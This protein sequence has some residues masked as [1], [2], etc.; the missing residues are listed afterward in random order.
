MLEM[1]HRR[2]IHWTTSMLFQRRGE[3]AAASIPDTPAWFRPI[4]LLDIEIGQP[5]AAIRPALDH[6]GQP[7][8]RALALLRW[9]DRPVA[10]VAFELPASGLEPDAVRSLLR[11]ELEAPSTAHLL[12]ANG[13]VPPDVT[14]PEPRIAEV[15]ARDAF[16]LRAPLASVVIATRNRPEQLALCLASLAELVYPAFEIIVVD[17]APS[18][19]RTARY[20]A[21][22]IG[23]RSNLRYVREDRAGLASAHNCGVREMSPQSHFVAFTDDDVAVD[24][25]WLAELIRGFEAASNVGCVTG[26]IL[27]A[28]LETWPQLLIE[29]F[30]GFNKGFQRQIFDLRDHRPP[31]RLF[32]FT[33]GRFGSGANMA[34]RTETL[35][36][37]GGF[38]PAMGTGTAALGGD[39][40]AAFFRVITAGEALVYEPAAIVRHTHYRAYA[41]L[42]RQIHGYGVGL[43]AFLTKAIVDQP[44][45]AVDLLRKLPLGLWYALSACSGKNQKKGTDYPE[46]LTRLERKGLVQGPWAYLRSRR[47]ALAHDRARQSDSRPG[48]T[49][50]Q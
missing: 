10:S 11:R 38:D 16:L 26:L 2:G 27:P 50:S 9:H 46:E 17:N 36:R 20:F 24:R 42:Q 14:G 43:T 37:I 31:D 6:L 5:L 35:A 19:D 39:D 41:S 3:S 48:S 45:L 4:Q 40:L 25:Y 47:A 15:A 28:E 30:G 34:F 12:R 44:W 32:P 1:V 7:Y 33:P 21:E 49:L 23:E 8:Q 13:L 18:D 22:H 29:E